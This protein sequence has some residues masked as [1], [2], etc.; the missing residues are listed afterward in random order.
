MTAP[1]PAAIASAGRA[2][3]AGRARRDA[4]PAREA[5][6]EAYVPG[7]PTVDD[8]EQLIRRQRGET[9]PLAS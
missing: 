1:S 5:A 8:L 7:G 3:A 9:T 4:L 6:Q 2:L